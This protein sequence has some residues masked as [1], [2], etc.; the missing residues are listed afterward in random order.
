MCLDQLR[1]DPRRKQGVFFALHLIEDVAMPR[2]PRTKSDPRKKLTG[3][4][5]EGY[6]VSYLARFDCTVA[7]LRQVLLRKAG[8][9]IEERPRDDDETRELASTV[10]QSVDHIIERFLDVGYLNDERFARGL[11][12]SLFSRGTAPRKTIERLKQR[13]VSS[14]LA[15]LIVQE[16]VT[17]GE[18]ELVAA[19]R[20]VQRKRLGWCRPDEVIRKER[21]QKDLAA[22]ARAGFS[23]AAAR[24]ALTAPLDDDPA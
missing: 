21:A 10:R 8:H 15:A 2:S 13:G 17:S 23:F 22:L 5:L 20:L 1:S 7:K 24:R 3:A 14:E 19:A 18:T 6:A 16:C 12:R 9:G 11:A 4:E